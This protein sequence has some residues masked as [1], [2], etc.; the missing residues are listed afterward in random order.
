MISR[1]MGLLFPDNVKASHLNLVGP[2]PPWPWKHPIVFL[3]SLSILFSASERAKLSKLR[4]Y[5]KEGSGYVLEQDTKP[6]TVGYAL[7]DSPVALLGWVYEKLHDW[8]DNYPWTDDEI[9]TWISIYWFSTAGPA[10]S[11]RIYHESSH[12][13]A[14]GVHRS[15]ALGGYVPKVKFA[16]AAFP[17]EPIRVPTAWGRAI[18]N[19]VRESE[20]ESGG[21]FAAWEKPEELAADLKALFSKEKGEAFAVVQ[22]RD[23]Y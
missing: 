1:T 8:T 9:L 3:Q 11:A 20:F 17:G 23:G 2:N 14:G 16:V 6:Q 12:P 5:L 22:G 19:V 13:P 21:H 4:S 7:Q 15:Q 18:G 10:A